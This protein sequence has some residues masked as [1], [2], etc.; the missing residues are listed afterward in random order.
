MGEPAG[1][2]HTDELIVRIGRAAS[3][4]SAGATGKRGAIVQAA[5]GLFLRQ[6]YQGTSTDQIA[7][8]AAVSKQTVYNQFRDKKTLFAEIILGVTATAERFAAEVP[9]ELAEVR[10]A[11]DLEPALRSLARRYLSTV[12][13]PQVLAVRRLIIG[14]S[15]RFP[16]LAR[17]YHRRAPARVLAALADVFSRLA[18]R[19]LLTGD[20]GDAAEDFAFLVLGPALDRGMFHVDDDRVPEPE[21]RRAADRAV[22]VFLASYRAAR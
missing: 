19:G 14:E 2:T 18:D 8:A 12:L 11:D 9:A 16:E 5:T 6:G 1:N 4:D 10:A 22:A 13:N 7:A 21:I 3:S 17:E 15:G 20:P